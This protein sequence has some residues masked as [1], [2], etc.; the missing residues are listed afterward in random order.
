MRSLLLLACSTLALLLAACGDGGSSKPDAGPIPDTDLKGT[1]GG[2][3]FVGKYA[4]ATKDPFDANATTRSLTIA[5]NP[6]TCGSYSLDQD[7]YLLLDPEW[8]VGGYDISFAKGVTFTYKEGTDFQNDLSAMG[9]IEVVTAPTAK[10][11]KGRIRI[12]ASTMTDS[13]EGGVDV[14]M[15][16]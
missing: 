16:E 14:L 8:V 12:R 15:C 1:V 9:R 11:A 5:A 3:D 4:I 13:V 6:L 7:Q 10:D 2:K